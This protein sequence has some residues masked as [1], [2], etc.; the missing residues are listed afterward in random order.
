MGQSETCVERNRDR[1]TAKQTDRVWRE[2]GRERESRVDR[3]RGKGL[4][5]RDEQRRID[6]ARAKSRETGRR[7]DTDK[8]AARQAQRREKNRGTKRVAQGWMERLSCQ[9][10]RW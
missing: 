5:E 6:R 7:T 2:G 4:V 9:S 1:H 10:T 3:D 8:Q